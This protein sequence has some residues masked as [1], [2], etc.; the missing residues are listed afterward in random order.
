LVLT[1]GEGAMSGTGATVEAIWAA[2]RAMP[3]ESREKLIERM[4]ADAVVRD[5][6]EDLMDIALAEQRRG[7]PT[8]PLDQVLAEIDE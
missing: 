6:I 3:R 4:L 1:D 2:F 8:R 5:E 7:E